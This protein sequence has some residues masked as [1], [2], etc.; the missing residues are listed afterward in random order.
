MDKISLHILVRGGSDFR[1][2]RFFCF[3]ETLGTCIMISPFLQPRL[4]CNIANE[5]SSSTGRRRHRQLKL[6]LTF[7]SILLIRTWRTTLSIPFDPLLWCMHLSQTEKFF[8]DLCLPVRDL[9]RWKLFLICIEIVHRTPSW[10]QNH[11]AIA[12][13]EFLGVA[14]TCPSSDYWLDASYCYL[15][16]KKYKLWLLYIENDLLNHGNDCKHALRRW[17]CLRIR[18]LNCEFMRTLLARIFQFYDR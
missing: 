16:I 11:R 18:E 14:R 13:C 10:R 5:D 1:G 15:E 12:E 2:F 4:L 17:Y 3:R 7:W 9:N 6:W 8:I